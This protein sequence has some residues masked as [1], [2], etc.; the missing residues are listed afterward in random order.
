MQ[1]YFLSLI[2]V[3]TIIFSSVLPSLAKDTTNANVISTMATVHIKGAVNKPGIYKVP[4]G[5]RL[6]DL[7]SKAG[8]LKKDAFINDINL[9]DSISDGTN[10]YIATKKEV[11][12]VIQQT[13]VENI[14]SFETKTTKA[15]IEHTE[16]KTKNQKSK[17]KNK[18]VS[19]NLIVN[20]NTATLEQLNNLPGIGEKMAEN[21]LSYRAKKGKFKSIEELKNI[22]RI[23]TKK[24]NK[25]KNKVSV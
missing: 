4:T 7:L 15:Y 8:G 23:G 14:H 19:P 3:T 17:S 25:L 10:I 13:K 22:D 11:E 6:V 2:T 24:F 16:R 1:K 20:L 9:T 21:I 12:K 18:K 5:M